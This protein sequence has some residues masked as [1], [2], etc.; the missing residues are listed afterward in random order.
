MSYLQ[1]CFL[2][3]VIFHWVQ[4][5]IDKPCLHFLPKEERVYFQILYRST[6]KSHTGQLKWV[7][8]C[9]ASWL[10][11]VGVKWVML[12]GSHFSSISQQR[13]WGIF[14]L[15][16]KKERATVWIS[17]YV[18][19]KRVKNSIEDNHRQIGHSVREKHPSFLQ[20]AAKRNPCVSSNANS[21][22]AKSL[23][24]ERIYSSNIKNQIL[25]E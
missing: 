20:V 13:G 15:S 4:T 11:I 5:Q 6:R 24:V 16:Q 22:A 21:W 1:A 19:H 18:A 23:Y 12:K 25:S 14:F 8:C 2:C 10:S 7:F 17:A 9:V 3:L